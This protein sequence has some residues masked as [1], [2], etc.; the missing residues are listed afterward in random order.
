MNATLDPPG[1][2]RDAPIPTWFGIGGKADRLCRPAGVEALRACLRT[3][4]DL[5]ILG[6]GANLLV[7]DDGVSKLVVVLDD[8]AFKTVAWDAATGLVTAGAGVNLPKLIN[9]AV[10]RGLGGIEGLGGIPASLGGAVRMNAGGSFG[11]ISSAVARV[12][13]L[14]R[15]GSVVTLE[16]AEID[17]G[18][19]RSG[20]ND[21][22]ITSVELDLHEEDPAALRARLKEVMAYKSASQPM[23][24]RSAG[25]V[26]KNPTLGADLAEIGARGDR[27][28]AGMLIDKAG[29]KGLSVGGASVS[30]RHGNFIVTGENARARDVIDLMDVVAARVKD[31]FG[32]CLE[33]EVVVWRRG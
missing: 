7:D 33:P 11:Q 13:G 17:F 18:Y 10:R 23:A 15:S 24:D 16:R 14:D 2:V 1:V 22:I 6:D 29:C 8:A 32:V 19:R 30:R 3:D 25:C 21:L 27:V 31:A 28:S 26:F 20:L 9:E 12:H 5:L 4:P